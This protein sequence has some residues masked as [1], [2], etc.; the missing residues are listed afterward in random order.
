MT[1]RTGSAGI[2]EHKP[3]PPAEKQCVQVVLIGVSAEGL[4]ALERFFEHTPTDSGSAFVVVR[5]HSPDA[6]GAAARPLDQSSGLPVRR[7]SEPTPIEPDAIYLVPPGSQVRFQNGHLHPIETEGTPE[8][9]I[10]AC[11]VSLAEAYGE[12][13]V[14]VVL[15]GH[16]TD[17]ARGVRAVRAAG[18]LV[19]AQRE[20]TAEVDRMPRAALETGAVDLALPPGEIPAVL[21]RRRR[22]PLLGRTPP[23]PGP[24]LLTALAELRASNEHL[25]AENAQLREQN[26]DQRSR[27]DEF[28]RTLQDMGDIPR[29]ADTDRIRRLQNRLAHASR[30]F[31]AGVWRWEPATDALIWDDRTHELFGL[32]PGA[33]GG[34]LED[35]KQLVHHDDLPR[36]LEASARAMRGEDEYDVTYRVGGGGKPERSIRA[37]G[38][39]ERDPEGRPVRMNG[40]CIDVTE[41]TERRAA[42]EASEAQFRRIAE[43]ID[44]VF[45][46][47]SPDGKDVEY[48]SPAYRRILGRPAE[49]LADNGLD[50]IEAIHPADRG[51]V[52]RAF[53]E[54]ASSGGFDTEFRIVRSD[55]E[56]RWI[57]D[58]GIPVR[59]DAG[60]V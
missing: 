37:T 19:V 34:R 55:G 13:A 2:H 10:D 46:I 25:R 36:A 14:A 48:I 39:V 18:G 35:W 24:D 58:R 8:N 40:L 21:M 22:A 59:N 27:I 5:T 7:V 29:S 54:T 33:F 42:L 23:G 12:R 56:T 38:T 47:T 30:A 44:Q 1:H 9:P 52:E 4:V 43:N 60:E 41:E 15:A 20:D 17:G 45:W 16:G 49:Q 3:A 31:G 53:L 50:W 11:F 28:N 57:H 32:D 6:D 26:T 51:G